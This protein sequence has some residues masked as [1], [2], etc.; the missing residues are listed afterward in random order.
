MAKTA[1]LYNDFNTSLSP[2][3]TTHAGTPAVT[4][5]NL[6]LASGDKVKTVATNWDLTSSSLRVSLPGFA[7]FE[8]F[9]LVVDSGSG[10]RITLNC[11]W[12]GWRAG[13]VTA[14]AD[15]AAYSTLSSSSTQ[16]QY[17]HLREAG[18][19]IYFGYS[20]DGVTVTEWYSDNSTFGTPSS[21]TIYL[22]SDATTVSVDE[23]GVAGAAGTPLRVWMF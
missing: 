11:N 21:C 14:T 15:P 17:G 18:G 3:F 4:G 8:G 1:T 6:V 5:G 13:F 2:T 20:S 12:N 22:I 10:N 19:T 7:S 9:Y 16:R 23:I